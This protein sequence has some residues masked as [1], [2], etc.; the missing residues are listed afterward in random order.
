MSD[1]C[2]KEDK[3]YDA[4]KKRIGKFSYLQQRKKFQFINDQMPKSPVSL[5]LKKF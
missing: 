1:W 4:G 5:E 3:F 2:L